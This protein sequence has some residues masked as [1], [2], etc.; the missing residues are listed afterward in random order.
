MAIERDMGSPAAEPVHV[1]VSWR[2]N[3]PLQ[4][5]PARHPL[6][7]CEGVWSRVPG[8]G[9]PA[10]ATSPRTPWHCRRR[11]RR[12]RSA[13]LVAARGPPSERGGVLDLPELNVPLCVWND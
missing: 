2:M 4:A 12:H 13:Q 1:G 9:R 6:N 5:L 11:L 8:P 10:S 7:L 3:D